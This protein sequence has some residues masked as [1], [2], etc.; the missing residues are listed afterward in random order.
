MVRSVQRNDNSAAK[1]LLTNCGPLSLNSDVG[2][3]YGMIKSFRRTI[4]TGGAVI[5][6]TGI[7]RVS[8][9]YRLVIKMIC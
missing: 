5:F 9:L 3:P 2:I 1:N 4:E 6:D 8:F 7:A